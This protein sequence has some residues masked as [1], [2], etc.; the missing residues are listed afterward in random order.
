M[1]VSSLDALLPLMK[2]NKK[3]HIIPRRNH[4]S[5]QSL[6]RLP[7]RL[8]CIVLNVLS[9]VICVYLTD[10]LLLF[11]I[12][13]KYCRIFLHERSNYLHTIVFNILYLCIKYTHNLN[14]KYFLGSMVT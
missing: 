13:T 7:V 8:F 10:V 3:P 12:I 11:T 14:G 5:C 2:K 1:Y 9:E 4:I 6:Q